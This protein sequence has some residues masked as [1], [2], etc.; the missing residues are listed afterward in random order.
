MA[1]PALIDDASPLGA[2]SAA[3]K[4]DEGSRMNTVADTALKTVKERP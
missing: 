4:R 1:S 2:P 3:G